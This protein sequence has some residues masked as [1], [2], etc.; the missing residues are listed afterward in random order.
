MVTYTKEKPESIQRMFGSI[1]QSY[2]KTNSILSFQ[3][4]KKWNRELVK[5]V[6]G[7]NE[8]EVLLD[9]CCGT[10]DIAFAC[11]ANSK[12]KRK[13]YLLDFCEEMLECA[14]QKSHSQGLAK[15][16]ISY[17]Q[18]DAQKI[19]LPSESVTIATVAYGIRNIRSPQECFREAYRVLAPGG[20]F[21]ILELTK[22]TNPLV[23]IG[24]KL[25]LQTLPFLGKWLTNNKDAYQYLR[26]S[27]HSFCS[28]SEITR[29]LKEEG[30]QQVTLSPLFGGIATLFTCT[31]PLVKHSD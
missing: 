16:H 15:H 25:Y 27:I 17:L 18:A 31:K 2:D 11:L 14:R 21:G 6:G 29:M 19:P 24:H 10:G 9:L 30:F 26:Q 23:R 20:K 12:T 28:P 8:E 5:H 7:D 22:P 4:H 1:A 13:A 3:L